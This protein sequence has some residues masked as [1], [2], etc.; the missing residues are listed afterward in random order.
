MSNWLKLKVF[1]ILVST[2]SCAMA[3]QGG[4]RPTVTPSSG[5]SPTSR[6]PHRPRSPI[7]RPPKPPPKPTT[8][9]LNL[10][11]IPRDSIVELDNKNQVVEVNTGLL[12]LNAIAAGTHTLLVRHQGYR[13]EP[14]VIDI[15]PGETVA[16]TL[17]LE[18]LKGVLSVRPN[19]DG[20]AIDLRNLTRDQNVGS[21]AGAIDHI[22]IPPGDYEITISKPGYVT[23]SRTLTLNAGSAL[24]I[25]PRLEPMPPARPPR[26]R[27]RPMSGRVDVDGKYLLVYLNGAS[28]DDTASIGSINVTASRNQLGAPEISGSLTGSPCRIEFF[29]MENIDEWSLVETPSPS[30]QYSR[31][32]VR[33]RP[34]DSKRPL[35]FAI[36][37]K[38]LAGDEAS[39]GRSNIGD[40]S[41]AVAIHKVIPTVPVAARS[42]QI[43]G[44]VNVAVA[45]DERGNVTSAK[46][47]DGPVVLRQPAET[48][49]RLWR[50]R[51]ATRNGSPVATTQTIKFNFER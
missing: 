45:I 37:W 2:A 26:P 6:A 16:L 30:N 36:N 19:I 7:P 1:S 4:E 11:V 33:V 42:G 38:S 44:T 13:D 24:E 17:T 27:A 35:R 43:Y 48:A 32:V 31:I 28:E 10:I 41:E 23:T 51:P 9:S 8:G 50:F 22:E 46:A 14:R 5:N 25:E 21:F 49:A 40:F 34:K 3:F 15:V 39:S 18:V 12:S 29:K 20:S 47:T